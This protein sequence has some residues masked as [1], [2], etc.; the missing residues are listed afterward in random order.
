LGLPCP[1]SAAPSGWIFVGTA[2]GEELLC[3]P[4]VE[5]GDDS[6]RSLFELQADQRAEFDEL[7][8]SGDHTVVELPHPRGWRAR[9]AWSPAG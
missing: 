1:C 6:L 5:T 7:A 4:L 2:S 8:R 9:P 3:M